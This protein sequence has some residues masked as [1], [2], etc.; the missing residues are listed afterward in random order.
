MHKSKIKQISLAVC[1]IFIPLSV[2]SAGLGKLN[3]NSGLGEPLKAEIELL[4]VSPEELATLSA[5]I[6]S[7]EAYAAQGVTRLGIHNYIQVDVAKNAS[8]SPILKLHSRQPVSD[9]Y[10]D[11]LIQVD[12]ATGRLQREYTVLLDPPG[13]TQATDN[14]VSAPASVSPASTPMLS[15]AASAKV[16]PDQPIAGRVKKSRRSS[17]QNTINSNNRVETAQAKALKETTLQENQEA[18]VTEIT[19]QRGD[20]LATI[21]KKTQL[22]GVSLDQMLTGLYEH[23]KQAF[24]ADNMNRLKV[25]Q[26]IKVPT[27]ETLLS[28]SP[29]EASKVVKLQSSNWKVYRNK[30][31]GMVAETPALETTDQKQTAS[32]KIDAAVDKAAPVKVGPQD[33]VKLSAGENDATKN[34]K[35]AGKQLE[36]KIAMLQEETTARE[37]SLKEAQDRTVALQQQIQDMQ[38]LLALKNQTMAGMQKNAQTAVQTPPAPQPEDSPKTSLVKP[39]EN[40]VVNDPAKLKLPPELPKAEVAAVIP[41]PA[42]SAATPNAV[43]AK[44]VVSP[45]PPVQPLPEPSFI[46]GLMSD[47]ANLTILLSALGVALLGAGWMFLRRKRRKDL[48]SFERGILTSGGLRANTVFGNTT[49]NASTS[50]T[51]FLTDFAQ[52]ADGNMIDTNDVDPIAEAEVYMA[53]G[54]D[55]QAEEILKDAI[56]KEPKRYELH[57]KLLEMYATRKDT[58]AFEA[59]AGELYTTLGANDVTWEKVAQLGA[60]MEPGNPLYNISKVEAEPA[61]TTQA[62][63]ASDFANVKVATDSDL[64]F[65]LD[66]D[67]APK[68]NKSDEANEAVMQSFAESQTIEQDISFD[69]GDLDVGAAGVTALADDELETVKENKEADNSMDFDLGDFG[70][71]EAPVIAE[72]NLNHE[73]KMDNLPAFDSTTMFA[74]EPEMPALDDPSAT[75]KVVSDLS[76]FNLEFDLPEAENAGA[77]PS[78]EIASK[79]TKDIAFDFELGDDTSELETVSEPEQTSAEI[80][81]DLPESDV[82]DA[83]EPVKSSMK[84]ADFDQFDFSSINL[85]LDDSISENN[86][87]DSLEGESE[88]VAI[89][90]DLVAAYIEMDDKEG[91]KELLEEVMKE[92]GAKQQMRAQELLASLS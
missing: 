7:E 59:I 43:P 51:S 91:A 46:D 53:Y 3:L 28:I 30:L 85:N 25:G 38:K 87:I 49:G 21:A 54:R 68:I 14:P 37:K 24:S 84:A 13:Y 19:T 10:L 15:N 60:E 65:A 44:K 67:I 66:A 22:D 11:M 34:A 47:M 23:N 20:T 72:E 6:A 33:V 73:E 2:Y 74:Q 88:D 86:D 12:W 90:L 18:S 48:D 52:S 64:D 8:G 57:L 4:S 35:V 55:A 62:L 70:M 27:K 89:K 75:D 31:A 80:S 50:D 71:A 29:V 56:S 5:A 78:T 83:I 1:L 42:D 36:A 39:A 63:N 41:K 82:A 17:H 61:L 77:L 76:D 40:V 81:F 58:S 79:P 32:G 16:E 45:P 26:I 92:G 9:P 69:M